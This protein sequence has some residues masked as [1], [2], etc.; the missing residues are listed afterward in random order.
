MQAVVAAVAP[1]YI[2]LLAVT[3]AVTVA[4]VTVCVV[5]PWLVV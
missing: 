2:L 4:F 5:D 3:L 1:S